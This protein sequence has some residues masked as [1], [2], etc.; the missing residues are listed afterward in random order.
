MWLCKTFSFLEVLAKIE[1]KMKPWEIVDSFVAA[2]LIDLQFH[3]K[4]SGAGT[5]KSNYLL[6]SCCDSS[7]FCFLNL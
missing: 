1:I 3:N 4:V 5:D 2:F 6:N 7:K